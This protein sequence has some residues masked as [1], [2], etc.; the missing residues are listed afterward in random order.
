MKICLLNTV[1]NNMIHRSHV[2]PYGFSALNSWLEKKCGYTVDLI[3]PEIEMLSD[4]AIY[5]RLRNNNYDIVGLGG[6]WDWLPN[7][8]KLAGI[9]KKALPE[10]SVVMGG[11]MAS[12]IPEFVLRNSHTDFVVRGEG[13]LAFADLI[14]ALIN[15]QD[16]T[17]IKGVSSVVDG[18]FI[19]N[20]FGEA[21]M[22]LSLIPDH[23]YDKF[24][25]AFYHY[26]SNLSEMSP[27]L[28]YPAGFFMAGRGCPFNCNF[29]FSVQKFRMLEPA[30]AVRRLS[31]YVDRYKL[32][33]IMMN[34]DTFTIS[35]K[36]TLDFCQQLCDAHLD[37]E[38]Y[39]TSHVH[40]FNEEIAEALRES[41]CTAVHLAIEVADNDILKSMNKPITLE[42]AKE[43]WAIAKEYGIIPWISAMH[44]QPGENFQTWKKTHQ[45]LLDVIDKHMV[46]HKCINV[47]PLRVYPGAALYSLAKDKGLVS[48]D[49]E[50]Y[51]QYHELN[52]NI[53]FTSYPFSVIQR[54]V[55][56]S[57]Q[58]ISTKQNL[59][60]LELLKRKQNILE[61]QLRQT[62]RNLDELF[63]EYGRY[64]VFN[65][66]MFSEMI[67]KNEDFSFMIWGTG[68]AFEDKKEVLFKYAKHLKGFL[69]NNQDKW[70]R[71]FYGYIVHDPQYIEVVQPD[72]IIVCSLCYKE[73]I[74]QVLKM[75]CANDIHIVYMKS[76][77]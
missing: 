32:K 51:H 39:A 7:G 29:C 69:D 72:V 19:D 14:K 53:A 16:T 73:I 49:D 64:C 35:R 44:G 26:N 20:G 41:G 47:F 63:D 57:T 42:R 28:K 61:E 1:P 21:I 25:M 4:Q 74:N 58:A 6:F 13:E 54:L 22:D 43:C 27:P 68:K 31:H 18:Q 50:Y 17:K 46:T 36:W 62:T 45:V 11:V 66:Y 23:D 76:S 70:E 65:S 56:I 8:I 38:Y 48:S 12:P 77:V 30:E 5:E 33:F 40:I 24:N 10:A 3:F 75:D 60:S 52:E 37:I 2:F 59:L 67:E 34:D 55:S 9:A 15:R 71:E